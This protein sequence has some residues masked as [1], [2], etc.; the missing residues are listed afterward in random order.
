MTATFL[1]HVN[2]TVSNPQKTA[3]LLCDL[4]DWKIRWQGD[5]IDG[6]NTIHVGEENSY[7]AV[8]KNPKPQADA[9]ISYYTV[10]GLN[11]IAMVVPDLDET[12]KRVI[13]AGFQTTN[14]GDYEP[15]RRFYFHDSDG[16]EYEIVSYA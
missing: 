4:F 12:E 9:P 6:G 1:E 7:V 14:H 15:G 8:Y 5:S 10:G 3:K 13:S 2:V 11:H 16:I